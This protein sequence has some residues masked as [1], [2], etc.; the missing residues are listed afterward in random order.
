LA[1][2][3]ETAGGPISFCFRVTCAVEVA[4]LPLRFS[5]VK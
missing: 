2:V 4:C 3:S 1:A 5:C